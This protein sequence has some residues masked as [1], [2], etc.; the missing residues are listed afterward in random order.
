M[1]ITT[2]SEQPLPMRHDDAQRR[3]RVRR[4]TLVVTLVVLAF[5]F[6]FIAMMLYRATR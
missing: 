6:G 5:Y 1:Q 2:S 4:T 3:K